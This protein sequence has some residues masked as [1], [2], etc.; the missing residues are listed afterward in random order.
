MSPPCFQGSL[1]QWFW[2]TPDDLIQDFKTSSSVLLS[3]CLT[4][5][6]K[7]LADLPMWLWRAFSRRR[8]TQVRAGSPFNSPL[9][10]RW[11]LE[12]IG[13]WICFLICRA[14]VNHLWDPL[15]SYIID[16]LG[17]HVKLDYI[18]LWNCIIWTL[19]HTSLHLIFRIFVPPIPQ[20]YCQLNRWPALVWL[21][22][23]KPEWQGDW[24]SPTFPAGP[25]LIKTG[26]HRKAQPC[27]S[28]GVPKS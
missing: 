27:A 12:M 2:N 1:L 20:H 24:N 16:F 3:G 4:Q 5:K 8:G 13:F 14:L 17:D 7:P 22:E 9:G 11:P 18:L 25:N 10:P 15:L 23:L 21:W 28:P 26:L 6:F 19:S